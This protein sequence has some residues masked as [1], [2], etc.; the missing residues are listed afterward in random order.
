MS[1]PLS[2]GDHVLISGLTSRSGRK[3]NGRPCKL[4]K[5]AKVGSKDT[6]ARWSVELLPIQV[7]LSDGNVD[8]S[9][10]D[11]EMLAAMQNESQTQAA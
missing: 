4:L 7:D 3:M 1:R 2:S 6:P 9:L 5:V 10:H 8:Y 11:R